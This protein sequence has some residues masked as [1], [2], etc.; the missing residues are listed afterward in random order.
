[1]PRLLVSRESVRKSLLELVGGSETPLAQKMGC[2]VPAAYALQR[3]TTALHKETL[4][5]S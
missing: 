4:F 3:A 1:M 2:G 5:R